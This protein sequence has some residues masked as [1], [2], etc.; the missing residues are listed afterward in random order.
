MKGR[1]TE[2]QNPN[3][4]E[5]I[6]TIAASNDDHNV[7][8]EVRSMVPPWS[9][10]FPMSLEELPLHLLHG[11]ARVQGPDIIERLDAIAPSEY[12]QFVSVEHSRV[13]AP[14]EGQGFRWAG[15]CPFAG[16]SVKD[17]EGVVV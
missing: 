3:I 9:W 17:I 13:R 4:A 6:A 15:L 14:R 5:T 1:H 7:S 10:F 12:I 2:V 8:N 16:D 11:H